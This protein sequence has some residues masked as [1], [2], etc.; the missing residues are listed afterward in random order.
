[1]DAA[2]G[3]EDP[4][5]RALREVGEPRLR[6][7]V[8]DPG[9]LAKPIEEQRRDALG[10][11]HA[12][13]A[14]FAPALLAALDLRAARGYQP[15]LDAITYTNANRSLRVLP[16][17]KLKVLPATWRAWALDEHGR[18]VRTR[19]ELALWLVVRDALRSRGLYR[20]RSHRYGDPL[21]WMMPR[22]QWQRERDELATIFDR[23]LDAT[24]RLR[25]LQTDQEQLVARLQTGHE[26]GERVLFDGEKIT[27]ER[28][29]E[30]R[31]AKSELARVVHGML[32]RV[33]LA[34]LLVE[35]NR[36]TGFLDELSHAGSSSARSPH[37]PQQ[38]LGALIAAA[39]GLGYAKMS[40][41]SSFTERELRSASERHLIAEHL[42]AGSARIMRH[43]R[44]LPHTAILDDALTSSDG[45]RYETIGKS[46]IG[47]FAAREVGY[48][49]RMITWLLWLTG[50][51]GH[52]GSK[53]IPVTEPES[54]HTLDALMH[55]DTPT[56]Q[57]TTDTH[58]ATELVFALFDLLGWEF[59]PRLKDLTHR[60]LYQIGDGQP[61]IAADQL[62]CGR[63]RIELIIEQWEE[64]LR[65]AGSL[66]RGWIVPSVLL[67]RMSTDQRP[68][69]TAKAL[70]EYGRLIET[71]F[72]LRWSGNPDMRQRSHGQLN[73]GESANAMRREVGYGNRGRVRA[74]DPEQLH[75][76]MEAR[77]LVANAIGYWNARYI[78]LAYK[79]LERDGRAL[80]DHEVR[81]V[82]YMHHEHVNFFGRHTVDLRHGPPKGKHRPL[83]PQP[84]TRRTGATAATTNET[85]TNR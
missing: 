32:P 64:L 25:D 74:Q 49:K 60:R 28:P 10:G 71:N 83:R 9:A 2:D 70:R 84:A 41:A 35:V 85:A 75:R 29:G 82:H 13:L 80:P 42:D 23:P 81:R 50:Q 51:Y 66:K 37:R 12:Y 30:Q 73:K 46:P 57:H 78:A 7:A 68:D 55:L 20:A 67:A 33:E 52:F 61:R 54:W 43:L 45:Q 24:V 62:F 6:A 1:M 16:D 69:R 8:D 40:Q 72:V 19:F 17:A 5:T 56:V 48:R 14:Q 39:T 15:L 58:G 4:L 53:V 76:H 21:G 38:V 47:A 18:V 79:Q 59:W 11:R 36:E 44:L 27:G 65:L 22:V 63:I 3:G 34:G 31:V 26:R 77:R